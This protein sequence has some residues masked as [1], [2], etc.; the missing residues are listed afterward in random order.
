MIVVDV[1]TTGVDPEIN[2]IIGIGAVDF[3]NSKNQ[4]YEECK[5]WY[6][7][8]ITK[9]ALEING[10]TF[11]Q[12]TNSRKQSLE[13]AILK[14][15][16][17]AKNIEYRT[18]AGENPAFDRDF[19]KE[20]VKIYKINWKPG[21]RT[22]D[23]H[24]L[25]YSHH[26]KRGIKPPIKEKITDLDLNKTLNYVGLP[27]EPNPHN[28]LVGAKYEAEAFSRLIYGKKLFDEFEKYPVP[29]YLRKKN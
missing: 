28:A 6:G 10:F 23:L 8:E 4:F 22:I 2:S 29:D 17:W 18:F 26:L 13:S 1:E 15:I 9:K 25:C 12:I 5:I 3:F 14:F 19:L 11:E 24:S 27:P 20:S 16:E 7:A 21:H